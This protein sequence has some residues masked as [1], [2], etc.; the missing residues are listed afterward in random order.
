[1]TTT[2]PTTCD[3]ST[4]TEFG[5]IGPCILRA[6]HDGPVHR[7]AT[8]T[9]WAALAST[10]P[11]RASIAFAAFLVLSCAVGLTV[12]VIRGDW[13]WALAGGIGAGITGQEFAAELAER[14]RFRRQRSS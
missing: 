9:T 5:A 6:G 10:V 14:R 7:D 11:S 4:R 2:A 8:G 12:A 1:M 3:R 13:W